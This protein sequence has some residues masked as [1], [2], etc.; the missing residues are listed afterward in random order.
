M[1]IIPIKEGENI[2][3]ALKKYKKKYERTGI[4]RELRSRQ[5]FTKPSIIRREEIKKAAYREKMRREM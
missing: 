3:R 1:L 5:D 2:D 4:L